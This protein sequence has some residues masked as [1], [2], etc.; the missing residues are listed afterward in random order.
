[1]ADAE[2]RS[3]KD[4][5]LGAVDEAFLQEVKDA[6]QGAVAN[7]AGKIENLSQATNNFEDR[8]ERAIAFRRVA[9]LI[10]EHHGEIDVG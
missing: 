9:Y 6:F 10:I 1:V 2:Q 4:R 8:I 7:L 3:L 5:A